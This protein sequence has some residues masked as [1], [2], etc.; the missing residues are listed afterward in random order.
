MTAF[1]TA[2]K[3]LIH[4]LAFCAALLFLPQTA[5]ADS[6]A[7]PSTQT[8]VSENGDWR[9]TIEPSPIS[10]A[11]GYFQDEVMAERTGEPVERTA[12]I[13]M[14]EKLNGESWQPVW[15]VQLVNKVAPVTAIVANDGEHVVTFDN[16]HTV[17]YGEG[18]VAIYGADGT[19]VRSLK[20]EDIIPADYAE[21]LP[22]SVSSRY[23]K[24]GARIDATGECLLL[25]VI[26]PDADGSLARDEYET[27]GFTI[28]LVSGIA[29]PADPGQWTLALAS[30]AVAIEARKQHEAERTAF[31]TEPLFAPDDPDMRGWHNYLFEA[32]YR[33][34]PGYLDDTFTSTTVLFPPSNKRHDE[35]VRWLIEEFT[36]AADNFVG[37]NIAVASPESASGL[38]RALDRAAGGV[39]PGILAGSTIYVS[40]AADHHANVETSLANT[41]ATFVWL[42]PEAGIPQRAE[43][44][45]GSPEKAAADEERTRRA[46]AE[47]D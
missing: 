23:W 38:I 41:G 11:L 2:R 12:P 6:W 47:M 18:V 16:W 21:V 32:F 34:T 43:R 33:L 25:H 8:T 45:P 15:A 1:T 22:A 9:V 31:F 37:S 39:A 10:S 13:A 40:I 30:A 7:P 14:L 17:G 29:A 46:M 26:V 3:A 42:D 35:S 5:G 20:L 24:S 19:L 4:A 28:N 27:T 36:D 44:V